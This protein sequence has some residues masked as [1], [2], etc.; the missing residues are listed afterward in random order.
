MMMIAEYDQTEVPVQSGGQCGPL[1][2]GVPAITPRS[3][4]PSG[5][6]ETYRKTYPVI[7][8]GDN[9]Y[10]PTLY[11]AVSTS[12]VEVINN[13]EVV[14]S[15]TSVAQEYPM[16]NKVKEELISGLLQHDTVLVQTARL[17]LLRKSN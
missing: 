1:L 6:C 8:S 17:P 7:I 5:L 13:K 14:S 3:N 12:Y 10:L 2:D 9:Y 4:C 16:L 11:Y 15:C